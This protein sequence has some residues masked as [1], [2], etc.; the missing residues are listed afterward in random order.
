[1]KLCVA[2]GLSAV[3]GKGIWCRRSPAD[4]SC[5]TQQRPGVFG[6]VFQKTEV[7]MPH[8]GELADNSLQVSLMYSAFST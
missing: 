2:A 7:A 3:Q 5:T 4:S 6:G 8:R 1:M